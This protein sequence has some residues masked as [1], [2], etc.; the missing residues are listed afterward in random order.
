M[1]AGD[2]QGVPTVALLPGSGSTGDFMARAFAPVI[3][4]RSAVVVTHA[5]GDARAIAAQL[6]ATYD[7]CAARG[8][9][10]TCVIG[11]SIGAH[12]AG[13][14]ASTRPS[15]PT[16]PTATDH[17]SHRQPLEL[18]LAMPAWTGA[19]D[20]IA[21]TTAYAAERLATQGVAAELDL[22]HTQFPDDWVVT[23]LDTAWRTRDPS[24]L[25]C[26]LRGTATS[27]SPTLDDLAHISI[28]TCV[29]A[30]AD[31][32][33][34][35]ADVAR[36]WAAAIPDATLTTVARAAPAADRAAFGNAVLAAWAQRPVTE[37]R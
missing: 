20:D 32:P 9:P 2:A 22:L 18:V 25:V 37:F 6:G 34:H 24:Q 17:A 27:V 3:D 11:V 8:T 10:I 13:W 33:L 19:P 5:S 36:T 29:V 16:H 35:P 23:E 31:D 7:E 15:K 28:P 26:S 12:A 14:W 1:C 4:S 21:A 30:L